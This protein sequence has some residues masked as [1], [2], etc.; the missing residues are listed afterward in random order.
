MVAPQALTPE[1]SLLISVVV[2]I[3]LIFL[4]A[5]ILMF[6]TKIFKLKD[7]R[8]KSA[9]KV[10]VIIYG[11]SI[12]YTTI[13]YFL[14]KTNLLISLIIGFV[15]FLL[16]SI[17]LSMFLIRK[18]YRLKWGKAALV[19]LVWT[20]LLGATLIVLIILLVIIIMLVLLVI[21]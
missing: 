17:L 16:V 14:P 8:Y 20:A 19:W 7:V 11:I 15:Y 12:I 9:L 6:S 5:L 2:G 13:K 21:Q 18:V 3:V 1:I 4:G 10:T